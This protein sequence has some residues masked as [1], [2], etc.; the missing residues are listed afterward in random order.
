V[1]GTLF[2][3]IARLA[4]GVLPVIPASAG[5]LLDQMGIDPGLRQYDQINGPWYD[6]L[7][8]T[9]FRVSQPTPLFPRLEIPSEELP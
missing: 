3:C 8:G 5:A 4:V 7:L 9:G 1:L 2:V 6:R